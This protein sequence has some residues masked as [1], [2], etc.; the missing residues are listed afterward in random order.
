MITNSD[1]YPRICTVPGGSLVKHGSVNIVSVFDW[2]Y[3]RWDLK[4]KSVGAII[5]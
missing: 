1:S 4:Q 2:V 3:L 5:V